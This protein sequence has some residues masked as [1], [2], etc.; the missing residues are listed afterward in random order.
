MNAG[1][2]MRHVT[3]PYIGT[4]LAIEKRKTELARKAEPTIE[5]VIEAVLSVTGAPREAVMCNKNRFKNIVLSRR[6]IWKIVVDNTRGLTYKF[7][8]DYFGGYDHTSVIQGKDDIANRIQREEHVSDI[9]DKAMKH[10]G[11]KIDIN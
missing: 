2:Q 11:L 10:L 1:I 4:W 6:M 5:Q 3:N 9:Y 7:I 8:G